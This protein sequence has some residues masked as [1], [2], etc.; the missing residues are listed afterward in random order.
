MVLNSKFRIG[1][2]S[3]LNI[4]S[5]TRFMILAM[6]ASGPSTVFAG[7]AKSIGKPFR[8]SPRDSSRLL[9]YDDAVCRLLDS[10]ATHWMNWRRYPHAVNIGFT[11]RK[12]WKPALFAARDLLAL[13]PRSYSAQHFQGI[14]NYATRYMVGPYI[15][16]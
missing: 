13:G 8:S 1:P 11:K 9:M 7:S 2:T 4:K 15:G 6:V 12:Q 16:Q 5:W 3:R 14:A 10:M